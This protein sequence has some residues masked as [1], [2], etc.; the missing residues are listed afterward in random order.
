MRGYSSFE[1]QHVTARNNQK[2]II[3]WKF[4]SFGKHQNKKFWKILKLKVLENMRNGKVESW[5]FAY[6]NSIESLHW[7]TYNV[8]RNN[9]EY[10]VWEM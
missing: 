3:A 10:Y 2:T 9:E 7:K 6:G 4:G 8:W 5:K 1:K